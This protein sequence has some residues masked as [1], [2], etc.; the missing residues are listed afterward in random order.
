[1]GFVQWASFPFA[2]AHKAVSPLTTNAT[3]VWIKSVDPTWSGYYI[4]SYLV[5]IFGGVPWQVRSTV[6]VNIHFQI[7]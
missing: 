4:D 3:E 2:M 1:M 5:V 7:S 6:Y